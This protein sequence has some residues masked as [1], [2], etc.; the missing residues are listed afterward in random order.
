MAEFIDENNDDAMFQDAAQSMIDA[1][2]APGGEGTNGGMPDAPANPEDVIDPAAAAP[3]VADPIDSAVAAPAAAP[4]AE[5]ANI[6]AI[7]PINFE[8]ISNGLV[9]TPEDIT[10][11]SGEYATMQK[12]LETL[13]EEKKRNPFAN[14]FVEILN[15]MQVDGKSPDQV[16]A[17]IKLQDLGDISKLTPLDAMIEARVLRDGRDADLT[18]KMLER[19]YEI[20]EGMDELDRQIAEESMKEDAKAD[21]EYLASQKK[22]LA[23]PAPA[24]VPDAAIDTITREQIIAQVAPIKEKVKDQFLSLG[25]INL[26]G[27]VDKDGKPTADAIIFDLP[28]PNEFREKIPTML[29]N[30]FVESGIPVTK[31]TLETAMGIVQYEMF[32]QYGVKIIQDA[33]NHSNTILEKK[34]RAEYV[35]NNPDKANR[36]HQP[37][38]AMNLSDAQLEKYATGE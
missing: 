23:A 1:N 13:R 15:Q 28:I 26:N 12:E 22:E 34:I 18:R 8:G 14:E 32:N 2:S 6:P 35:N 17:F 29:E 7:E 16:K 10:R 37:V 9:K 21:Y 27:K 25:E 4:A 38:N 19:K 20:T 24:K 11:I 5:P 30:Y 3:A 36:P 33:V 31:E